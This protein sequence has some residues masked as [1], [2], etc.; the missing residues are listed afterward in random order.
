[1][2]TAFRPLPIHASSR[3]LLG[4]IRSLTFSVRRRTGCFKC[5]LIWWSYPAPRIYEAFSELIT[6]LFGRWRA[7]PLFAFWLWIFHSIFS[8]RLP[9]SWPE[10]LR[11]H[12]SSS[13]LSRFWK[14]PTPH[15]APSAISTAIFEARC[16]VSSDELYSE[17][18]RLVNNGSCLVLP[19][20]GG[21]NQRTP[22]LTYYV[23]DDVST[24]QPFAL[25]ARYTEVGLSELAYGCTTDEQ[26]KLIFVAD[27]YRI[28]SYA[29]GDQQSGELYKSGLPTHTLASSKHTGPLAVVTSGSLI[30]A[31]KGSA[32]VWDLD[33]LPTH[34]RTGKKRIGR[35]FEED[36]MRDD[37]EDI[38]DS[39]GSKSTTV[40]KFADPH[41]TPVVWYPH[42][43]LPATMLCTTDPAESED[44]SFISLDLE[45]GGK[46]V[47]RYFGNGAGIGE[48]STSA[49][50]PNV[51]MTAANDGHMRLYDTRVPLP[52]LTICS[53]SGTEECGA[54]LLVHPDGI[55][56]VFTGSTNDQVVRLWDI[57][58][59]KLVHEL[60]T[61][62][63]G[64]NGMTWD[65]THSALYVS[66]TCGFMDRNGYTSDYRRARLP[67][68]MLPEPLPAGGM[69]N[70]DD[71][72]PF[73][74]C[75]P[76]QAIHSEDYWGEA[77]DAGNHRILRYA[78]KEHADPTIVPAYGRATLNSAP[79]Y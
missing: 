77:F 73:N 29:W 43:A 11:P 26:R 72:G 19:S 67:A 36:S 20:M 58:A 71:E 2:S 27:S 23:L 40:I 65:A 50:D 14:R 75:W 38:E 17:P 8:S 68:N 5:Q 32:V 16:E 1:M 12:P 57:R 66:T 41:L 69:P 21:Y 6:L 3:S 49:A 51:F 55:P 78:F 22:M 79:Y 30:R 25:T 28:K 53:A 62:N 24:D 44:Y 13:R 39:S 33:A 56:A 4:Q 60:S 34:G 46:Q 76:K 37:Y 74:K 48:F 70:Y 61:G 7:N 31:G 42:S 59:R 10:T 54:V 63:N 45:H 9:K 52:V 47:A 35:K 18:L 15:A 64:V